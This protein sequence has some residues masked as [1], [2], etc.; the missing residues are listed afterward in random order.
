MEM[1][2]KK[3]ELNDLLNIVWNFDKDE[4]GTYNYNDILNIDIEELTYN[5]KTYNTINVFMNYRDKY[6]KYIEFFVEGW[7]RP[8]EWTSSDFNFYDDEDREFIT[9]GWLRVRPRCGRPV[10]RTWARCTVLLF[11]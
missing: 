9:L 6:Y 7:G 2:I 3:I 11:V 5:G 10:P 8:L 4:D 1:N